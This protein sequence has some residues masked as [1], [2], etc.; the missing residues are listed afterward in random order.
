MH[1]VRGCAQTCSP[2][3]PRDFIGSCRP[4]FPRYS[5][6]I[7]IPGQVAPPRCAS[8]SIQIFLYQFRGAHFEQDRTGYWN[9][10]K[11]REP[12]VFLPLLSVLRPSLRSL[13]LPRFLFLFRFFPSSFPSWEFR[14][15][16]RLLSRARPLNS[17][18][19]E[20][21]IFSHLEIRFRNIILGIVDYL[22]LDKMSPLNI[23]IY[24]RLENCDCELTI[25]FIAFEFYLVTRP[26][27][28]SLSRKRR[29]P[30]ARGISRIPFISSSTGKAATRA[31][32]LLIPSSPVGSRVLGNSFRNAEH[33]PTLQQSDTRARSFVYNLALCPWLGR[34][35]SPTLYAGKKVISDGV[36]NGVR[37]YAYL[38][39][40]LCPC[41]WDTR[42]PEPCWHVSLNRRLISSIHACLYLYNGVCVCAPRWLCIC[43][44]Y[45]HVCRTSVI[46][47]IPSENIR[48]QA[49]ECL[50][51]PRTS[52]FPD[53]R[54]LVSLSFS[55]CNTLP[56]PFVPFYPRDY[57]F[58]VWSPCAALLPLFLSN[59]CRF[60]GFFRC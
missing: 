56:F 41:C 40:T 2:S 11:W 17:K 8:T 32:Y 7:T 31:E 48:R 24:I 22:H 15:T 19:R 23:E 55:L 12:R 36:S 29:P 46:I 21:E 5:F 18:G 54:T 57:R 49:Q 47:N 14:L 3:F 26:T 42:K 51:H 50:L 53:T 39:A 38:T 13:F 6:I 37:E 28:P 4:T 59:A 43:K 16:F 10:R 45:V 44:Q 52:F 9:I 33:A 58:A 27:H 25:S 60:C 20:F 1:L 35:V 34:N 30:F